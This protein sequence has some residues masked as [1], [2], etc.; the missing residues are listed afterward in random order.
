[1]KIN[2]KE[3]FLDHYN[4]RLETQ[5]FKGGYD[6]EMSEEYTADGY[7]IY[8]CKYF[9]DTIQMD[10]NVYYYTHELTD[11]LKEKIELGEN[12]FMS[13]GIY[14]ENGIDDEWTDWCEQAGLTEWDD[15]AQEYIIAGDN[16]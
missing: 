8:L 2:Y 14:D 7:S 11:L 10:E 5:D 16:K 12:I 13:E 3:L 1:M 15:E 4:A 9:N 6:F